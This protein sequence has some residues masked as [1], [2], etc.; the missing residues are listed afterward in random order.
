[1]V[2]TIC[3]LCFYYCGIDVYVEDGRVTHVKGVK[4]HPSNRGEICAKAKALPEIHHSPDRLRYPMIREG[5]KWKRVSWDEA[6]NRV[7]RKLKELKDGHEERSVAVFQGIGVGHYITKWFMM[8][9]ADLYGTPNFSSV[10]A[11]CFIARPMGHLLTYGG[12][13][14][15]RLEETNCVVLWGTDPYASLY[16]RWGVRVIEAKKRGAKLIV[17][18]PATNYFADKAELLLQPRPGTDLALA[19]GFMNVIINDG[20]YDKE[21]IKKWTVGFDELKEHI[22]NYPPEVVEKLTTVPRKKIEEAARMYATTKPACIH[23][24]HGLEAQLN[25]VQ[26]CRALAMLHALTG[27]VDVRGGNIFGTRLPTLMLRFPSKVE[28]KPL[29]SSEFPMFY[30]IERSAHLKNLID[31]MVEGKPYPMKV[32]IVAGSNPL[33]TWPNAKK[34]R[35]ALENLELLVVIDTFMTETAKLAHVVLPAANFLERYGLSDQGRDI[36]PYL[37]LGKPVVPPLGEA[38]PDIL[39][40]A[41]IAKKLGLDDYFPWKDMREA[42]QAII[43]PSGITIEQIEKKHGVY[44]S[45]KKFKSY[46]EKGFKTPSGKVEFYS[47]RLKDIGQDPIPTYRESSALNE[48]YPLILVTGVKSQEYVHSQF[49]NI[50][51]LRSRIPEPVLYINPQT[52]KRY[53]VSEDGLV[54]LKTENEKIK[55]KVKISSFVHPIVVAV[56][57]GWNEVNLLTDWESYDPLSGFPNLKAIPCN[58]SK[59]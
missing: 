14:V 31:A 22:I 24:G 42:I 28:E 41:A 19:L 58:I 56:G 36:T 43:A 59:E 21:F 37:A 8:R 16:P 4:E 33:V 40:F 17:I 7:A 35:R 32:L 54:V 25:G 11:M 20:L 53:N 18:D 2:R 23:Q 44:Y 38:K 3:E 57:S 26:T 13:T 30:E 45:Q 55:I 46:E 48:R 27:N 1:M 49:R 12:L 5:S 47:K 10:S 51:S 9:F 34:V 29:G 6:L 52:A 15:P 39:I 50:Q